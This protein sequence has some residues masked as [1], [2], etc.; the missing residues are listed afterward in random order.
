MMKYHRRS[1][2]RIHFFVR[3]GFHPGPKQFRKLFRL[4]FGLER[5]TIMFSE[6]FFNPVV[7]AFQVLVSR[8]V[9]LLPKRVRRWTRKLTTTTTTSTMAAK[10]TLR[11]FLKIFGLAF[12]LLFLVS[13][14]FPELGPSKILNTL[15]LSLSRQT[16]SVSRSP[17]I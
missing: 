9:N 17:A 6:I 12:F 2:R 8:C 5:E 3:L 10:R 4:S 16:R 11:R 14:V 13:F 7:A 15:H 1:G